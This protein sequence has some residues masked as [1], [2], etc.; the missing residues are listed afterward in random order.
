VS[1]GAAPEAL[2]ADA[3][4]LLTVQMS[5]SDLLAVLAAMDASAEGA[6]ED[7]IDLPVD[8]SQRAGSATPSNSSSSSSSVFSSDGSDEGSD[9]LVSSRRRPRRRATSPAGKAAAESRRKRREQELALPGVCPNNKKALDKRFPEAVLAMSTGE[10]N[11]YLRANP[12]SS[13]EKQQLREARRRRKNRV[14]AQQ[15]RLRR[16]HKVAPKKTRNEMKKD[17]KKKGGE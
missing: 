7:T 1:P 4:H 13:D 11:R 14:Y 6:A 16:I 10:L 2:S 12:L 8:R 15:S 9:E 17:E 3:M 5:D